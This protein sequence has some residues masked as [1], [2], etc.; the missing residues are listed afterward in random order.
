MERMVAFPRGTG[1]VVGG[2]CGPWRGLTGAAC[3]CELCAPSGA[4]SKRRGSE[5]GQ[6][7]APDCSLRAHQKLN[8][9]V[10][11]I[12]RIPATLVI[13]PK[14][15]EPSTVDNPLKFG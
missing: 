13:S 5:R 11:V 12:V 8:L 15:R 1:L 6:N 2:A 10:N 4:A 7:A 3:G 14:V 9:V